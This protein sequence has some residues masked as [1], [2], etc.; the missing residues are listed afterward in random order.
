[1]EAGLPALEPTGLGWHEKV[2][3]IMLVS[4]HVRNST[5]LAQDLAGGRGSGV[6]Q[7]EAEEQYGRSLSALIDPERFP[8]VARLLASGTRSMM[9]GSRSPDDP[10][11][12][13]DFVFGP[14]RILDG[15]EAIAGGR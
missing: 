2:R 9:P 6:A 14:E 11:A 1:M 3:T 8:P 15:T 10:A 12:D 4:G 13:P 5:L 7:A